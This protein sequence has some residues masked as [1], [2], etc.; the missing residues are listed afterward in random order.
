[1]KKA[2]F[3]SLALLFSTCLISADGSLDTTFGS[4]NGYVNAPDGFFATSV[5]IQADE[6]ILVA[7]ASADYE[8]QLVRYN[9]DGT[10]DTGFGNNGV[11]IGPKGLLFDVMVQPDGRIIVGG[12]DTAG[13][14]QLSRFYAQGYV[15]SS[16]GTNGAV[17]GPNGFCAALGLQTDSYIIAAGGNNNGEFFVLRYDNNGILDDSFDIGPLGFIEDMILQPDGK[18]VACGVDDNGFFSIVRYNTN[19]TIDTS[20]GVNGIATGPQGSATALVLQP[21]GNIV[22]AGFDLSTPNK[23]ILT[24]FD[25]DGALDGSFGTNGIAVGPDG[26]LNG[27]ILQSDDKIVVVGQ[28]ED[29]VRVVR[30]DSDGDIDIAFGINGIAATPKGLFYGASCQSDGKIVAV[31]LDDTYSQFLVARYTCNQSLTKTRVLEPIMVPTGQFTISGTAQNAAQVFIVL[32]DNLVGGTNTNSNGDD[33]WAYDITLSVPGTYTVRAVS[34]Y[35]A[36]NLLS[37]GTKRIRVY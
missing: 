5:A 20:F 19:G 14:F 37:A 10:I 29:N 27:M 21:D 28:Y 31:G 30:F 8:F 7:G 33:T 35:K 12:Q 17:V 23:M 11:V 25:G 24:R 1:M 2:F 9:A 13:N 32:D 26:V 34:E 18:V 6:Q 3:L 22:V 36:G 4:G 16:F 15:D